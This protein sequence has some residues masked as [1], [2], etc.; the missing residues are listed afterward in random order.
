MYDQI[1]IFTILFISLIFFIWGRWRYD[2]VALIA[3]LLATICGLISPD[4]AFHGFGH[5][6]VITVA[7][8]LII[9]QGLVNSGTIDWM[10]N[11]LLFMKNNYLLQASTLLFLVT[12]L[13]AFINNIGALSLMMPVAIAL[14]K[15]H[16]SNPSLILMPLAFCSL[17]GGLI[18]LI[19]TPPN[20][21]V[22]SYRLNTVGEPF[23][24]FAFTPVG[25]GVACAGIIIIAMTGKYLM[26]H[27]EDNK[28]DDDHFKIEDYLTEVKVTKDSKAVGLSIE[29]LGESIQ[30]E[31]TILSIIRGK[32]RITAPSRFEK[33]R[34]NDIILVEAAPDI[35]RLLIEQ[36]KLELVV[37]EKR[38]S[39]SLES[40]TIKL[41]EAVL[42]PDSPLIG[43]TAAQINLRRLYGVNLL[44]V[45][46]QGKSIKDRLKNLRFKNG[47]VLLLQ[48]PGKNLSEILANM[49][50]LP[51]AERGVRILSK[52]NAFISLGIFACALALTTLGLLSIH[53]AFIT[54]AACMI[55]TKILSLREAY[56]SVD[57]PI[58]VLL[59]SL[60]PVGSALETSGGAES[61]AN[62][63]IQMSQ[64]LSPVFLLSIIL[65]ITMLLTNIINNAAAAVLMCPIAFRVAES[66]GGSVDAFLMAVAV[67]S[68][69]AFLTPI[70]HQSNT[71][72]MG[73]GGY[74]FGDYWK[75]GLPLSIITVLAAV[76]LILFIWG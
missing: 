68:S 23:G 29:E 51:L 66:S 43:N 9:S 19:G 24:M 33:F 58:I 15:K 72:V 37:V 73:P 10:K 54:A 60:I 25:L 39:R 55:L 32:Q 64:Y 45:S 71:L 28:S 76:P 42:K 17:L 20:I 46:R 22:S 38:K 3:L 57:W 53:I 36:A 65:I 26:P 63:T 18:T 6:A 31:V 4:E 34:S 44:A 56:E 30:G 8:I 52:G 47:D 70:G 69:A 50:A 5:P 12:F 16:G 75:L 35:L 40:T 7:A 67:G 1:A 27:R 11:K 14:A 49:K 62:L 21:I 13:S 61:I 48:G 41:I 2:L 59:A 74:H